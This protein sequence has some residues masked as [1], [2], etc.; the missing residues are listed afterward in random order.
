[1]EEKNPSV[2]KMNK[3]PQ[4]SSIYSS[5]I[6]EFN[7]DQKVEFLKSQEQTRR[8]LMGKI[9]S[10]RKGVTRKNTKVL[11]YYSQIDFPVQKEVMINQWDVKAVYSIL[12]EISDQND[13]ELIINT[14]GGLPQKT[15]QV[16]DFLRAKLS[17]K[18]ILR[19]VVPEIAKSAGTLICLGGDLITVGSTSEVGLIDP[20][21]P[22][23]SSG[24]QIEYLSA[25]TYVN[26]LEMLRKE[27]KDKKGNLKEEFYPLLAN[28]DL[29]FYE[30][31][32][33]AITQIDADAKELLA[34]GMFRRE[35][36]KV[37][38]IVDYFLGGGKPHETLISGRQLVIKLGKK[39]VEYLNEKSE[40]WNLYWELHCRVTSLL[41]KTSIVK[42]VEYDSGNLNRQ[43]VLEPR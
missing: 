33:Q 35:Q 39:Y 42:L 40:L 17:R 32:K 10:L 27:S 29:P 24:G 12:S 26:A 11:L 25:W 43:V 37:D 4:N 3:K 6:R 16:I 36:K 7:R 28:F 2:Q 22:R 14:L 15:R 5:V 21:I 1:M 19:I 8:G 30:R 31:C 23:Y 38:G 41:D 18:N 13:I 20:Q 9:Q 34:R